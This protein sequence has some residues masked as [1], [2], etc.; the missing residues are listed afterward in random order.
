LADTLSKYKVVK[1]PLHNIWLDLG[2]HSEGVGE[3]KVDLMVRE[4]KEDINNK[5]SDFMQQKH[6]L[7]LFFTSEGSNSI[8]T[9]I[10]KACKWYLHQLRTLEDNSRYLYE[11][12]Q[13]G[14]DD[15]DS[16]KYKR[17]QLS[18]EKTFESLF[19]Q[20]KEKMLKI[21]DNF[22]NK[23]GKYAIQGYPNKLGLLLYGPPGTG[24]TS[25]I[26]AM[27]HLTGRSIVNIPLARIST[28]VELASIV[29]DQKYNIEG[30][31][32]PVKLG[33]KVV[34]FVMEDI[35]P[36]PKLSDAEMEKL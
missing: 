6:E 1:K 36:Y 23:T 7:T 26:K 25:L 30:E 29:F 12:K 16:R 15:E 14:N 10:D 32:V 24:K 13:P 19:F 11:L 3:H 5:N 28:N 33:F 27:A 18:D 22:T 35:A 8:D 21:V 34:I 20:E 17:Y 4:S 9:F 2:Q 31:R